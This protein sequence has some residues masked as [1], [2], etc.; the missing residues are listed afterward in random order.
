MRVV[1]YNCMCFRVTCYTLTFVRKKQLSPMLGASAIVR[2]PSRY[3][4]QTNH[5]LPAIVR[6]KNIDSYTLFSKHCAVLLL[7][8]FL[9]F[10]CNKYSTLYV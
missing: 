3:G 4:K 2:L 1:K 8:V 9:Y 7:Y 10:H 5:F 6:S